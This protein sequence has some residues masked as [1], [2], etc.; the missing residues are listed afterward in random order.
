MALTTSSLLAAPFVELVFREIAVGEHATNGV[1]ESAMREVKRQTRTLK[2]LLEPH[3][4]VVSNSHLI[5]R[6][7]PTIAA[8]DIS[9]SRIGRDGLTLVG[10]FYCR[11]AAKEA[12]CWPIPGTPHAGSQWQTCA[13]MVWR[14][15]PQGVLTL[16]CVAR[17]TNAG[18]E[19][20]KRWRMTM[21][22]RSACRHTGAG[23]QWKRVLVA[24]HLRNSKTSQC[25]L[26]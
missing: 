16:L 6:W 19:L 26:L 13:S 7:M 20:V 14:S 1:G 21:R 22:A 9:L 17:P 4:G 11:P 25:L 3:V 24:P 10:E 15:A 5:L 12:V 18:P 8:D 2:S 23:A